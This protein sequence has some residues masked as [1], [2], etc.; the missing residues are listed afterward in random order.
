MILSTET[1]LI[2]KAKYVDVR[3]VILHSI[4]SVAV[5]LSV[6]SA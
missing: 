1:S 3:N 2:A 5:Y 6:R 4:R